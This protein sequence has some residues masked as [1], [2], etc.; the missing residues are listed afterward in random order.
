MIDRDSKKTVSGKKA[1]AA[2]ALLV[3]VHVSLTFLMTYPAIFYARSGLLSLPRGDKYAF[4]W[5]F[6]WVRHSL[7][8][9]HQLPFFTA[10]QYHPTGVS[11]AF[12]DMTYFWSLLSVPLQSFMTPAQVLNLFL[13]LSFPLNALAFYKLAKEVSGDSFGAIAGSVLFAYNPYFLGRFFVSHPSLTGM[14]FTPLF[15]LSLWKYAH[16]RRG[17]ELAKAGLWFGLQ[18]LITFIYSIALVIIGMIF[19]LFQIFKGRPHWKERGFWMRWFI[20]GLVAI[21]VAAAI[22][23]PVVTPMV[24]QKFSGQYDKTTTYGSYEYYE[25]S[26]AD[27]VSYFIPDYSVAPWRGWAIH[28]SAT[29]WARKQFLSLYGNWAEKAVY[30]GWSG[31]IALGVALAWSQL[32]RRSLPWIVLA[33]GF[34]L[35]SLGPT[36]YVGGVPYLKGL[37]PGRFIHYV[38]LVNVF[39]GFTRFT[40]FVSLGLGTILALLIATVRSRPDTKGNVKRLGLVIACASV[41]FICVEFIPSSIRVTRE[42]DFWLSPFYDRLANEKESFTVL[43]IPVDFHGARGGADVYCFTQTVHKKPMVSGYVSR[44]PDYIFNTLDSYP[45]LQA[46]VQRSYETDKRLQLSKEGLA[47]MWR[48]LRDL[49]VR[50]IIV[51]RH[52]LRRTE[53]FRINHWLEQGPVK[54]IYEDLWIRVYMPVSGS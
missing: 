49:N 3:T 18:S 42:S 52:L 54:A 48:A 9:L 34:L 50:Y 24:A 8:E 6:W 36:L 40:P 23:L 31:W 44:E 21:G 28:P 14:F 30:P 47:N 32:R 45:F 7:L 38:P 22:I 43:N 35:M 19:F 33:L 51:H 5:I 2:A 41:F 46:V 10:L 27:L 15:L 37:L 25:G 12:H 39:R 26:S 17:S 20:H 1:M 29:K 13:L 4:M 53:W 16:H 11:L